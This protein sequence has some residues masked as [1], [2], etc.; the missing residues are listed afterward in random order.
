[1]HP[2]FLFAYTYPNNP[3][4]GRPECAV[5]FSEP[6]EGNEDSFC[7]GPVGMQVCEISENTNT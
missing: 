3:K 7:V 4:C 1:M 2:H 6:V 5:C